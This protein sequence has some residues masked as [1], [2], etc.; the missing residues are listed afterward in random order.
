[1]GRAGHR[2]PGWAQR[3][4][5]LGDGFG[6]RLAHDLLVGDPGNVPER[7]LRDLEWA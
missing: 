1:L 2:H 6:E 5:I 7:E 4:D 3:T